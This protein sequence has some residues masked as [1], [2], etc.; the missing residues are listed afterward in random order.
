MG[1]HIHLLY[2]TFFIPSHAANPPSPIIISICR[3]VFL[4][5]SNAPAGL[6][7]VLFERESALQPREVFLLNFYGQ[8]YSLLTLAVFY[9]VDLIPGFG[10]SDSVV[11][12]GRRFINGVLCHYHPA[13][14]PGSHCGEA[15][16]VSF[17]FVAA[18][19]SFLTFQV[20][21][22]ASTEGGS[23]FSLIVSYLA[24]PL[25]SVFW[26]LFDFH[27]D[28]GFVWSPLISF[29]AFF[30]I[31]GFST[32]LPAIVLFNSIGEWESQITN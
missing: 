12:F 17:S 29:T 3:K 5:L 7:L 19:A 21:L 2:F 31:L 10:Q 26:L 11:D 25:S 32:M 23:T 20:L 27:L 1:D 4:F 14:L 9:W 8:F 30:P 15:L 16:V 6:A 22:M 13:S 28:T 18:I 24:V